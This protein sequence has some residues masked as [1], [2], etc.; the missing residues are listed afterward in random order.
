M[1]SLTNVARAH[2]KLQSPRFAS[3][4]GV[5]RP[6]EAIA[7]THEWEGQGAHTPARALD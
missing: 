1:R 7:T 5:R 6:N 4:I 3:L 2:A